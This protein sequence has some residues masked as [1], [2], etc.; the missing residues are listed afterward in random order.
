MNADRL[1]SYSTDT[2]LAGIF[3]LPLLKSIKRYIFLCP[4]PMYL[5][6]RRPCTFL[7]PVDL[8]F[9]TK[10]FSGASEVS[11]ANALPILHR[12]PAVTGLYFL[13][14][15]SLTFEIGFYRICLNIRIQV[16]CF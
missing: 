7:P 13:S 6:E 14:A 10:V 1:G 2:T 9:S 12:V 3:F 15:I 11:S 8:I 16:N 5:M 4:P